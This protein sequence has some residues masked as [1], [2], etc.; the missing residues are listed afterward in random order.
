MFQKRLRERYI[1]KTSIKAQILSPSLGSRSEGIGVII[2][3]VGRLSSMQLTIVIS[4]E[5]HVVYNP[6][7]A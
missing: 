7:Q 5:S 1:Y 2:Y 6:H 3:W 4:L